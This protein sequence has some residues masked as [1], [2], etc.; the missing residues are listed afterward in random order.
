[1]VQRVVAIIGLGRSG[2]TWISKVVDSSPDVFYSHEPDYVVPV[3]CVP[4]VTD[5][6]DLEVWAGYFRDYISGVRGYCSARSVLKMPMF[7]KAYLSSISDRVGFNVFTSLLR[8]EQLVSRFTGGCPRRKWPSSVDSAKI[9]AWKSVELTGN[10]GVIARALPEER[11]LHVIRH[12][13]GFVD[14]VIRGE[15]KGLFETN[16]PITEDAGLFEFATRTGVGRKLGIRICDWPKLSKVERMAY[17]WL[18]MNEQA[19]EDVEGLDNCMQ[20]YFDEFCMKPVEFSKKIF[21]FIGLPFTSQ[22]EMF[23]S[24]SSVVSKRSSYFSTTRQSEQV[25]GNWKSSLD[26]VVAKTI[27]KIA[28]SMPKMAAVLDRN[29]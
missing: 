29:I 23:L 7:P 18:C 13:C 3:E 26:P 24:T 4:L 11:V 27:I 17:F 6:A 5:V 15:N 22:S 8:I 14:S 19:S 9:V 28:T 10:L 21:E 25:P 1:M 2:T 12:P 16:V 20:V